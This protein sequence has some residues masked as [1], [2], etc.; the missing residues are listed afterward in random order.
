MKTFKL[1]I[2]DIEVDINNEGV[3]T[4]VGSFDFIEHYLEM[5]IS[6]YRLID[7]ESGLIFPYY[8]DNLIYELGTQL[9][10]TNEQFEK[11]VR[12]NWGNWNTEEVLIGNQ[13]DHY[14]IGDKGF[15]HDMIEYYGKR[16]DFGDLFQRRYDFVI[17][18]IEIRIKSEQYV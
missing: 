11:I 10:E 5:K 16:S 12:E 8:L 18:D 6:E 13:L 7:I 4:R 17:P 9:P 14:Q 1:A 3:I 2:N 15:A